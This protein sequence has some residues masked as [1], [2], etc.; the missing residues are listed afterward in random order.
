MAEKVFFILVGALVGAVLGALFGI[1]QWYEKRI[2][3][4]E[5]EEIK[6]E[7]YRQSKVIED[8][9]SSWNRFLAN[10]KEEEK[11]FEIR[12]LS[13]SERVSFLEGHASLETE[14]KS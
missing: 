12:V 2:K 13:L 4:K 9:E 8:M 5:N 1:I 7:M 10:A 6:K 11:E 14:N 3:T